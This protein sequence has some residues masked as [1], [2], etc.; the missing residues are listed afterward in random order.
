MGGPTVQVL[1][2]IITLPPL[3]SKQTS[4]SLVFVFLFLFFEKHFKN[5]YYDVFFRLRGEHDSGHRVDLV[6]RDYSIFKYNITK[7]KTEIV[8]KQKSE[9]KYSYYLEL[10]TFIMFLLEPNKR[11]E[12]R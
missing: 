12:G 2:Q 11:Q 8:E 5:T 1:L 3:L 9:I 7:M 4:F 10:V 6:L